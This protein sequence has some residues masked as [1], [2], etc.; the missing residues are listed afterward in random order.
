ML[1][2]WE[3]A[4]FVSG[5]KT[6]K[7]QHIT[8]SGI[9]TVLCTYNNSL[10]EDEEGFCLSYLCFVVRWFLLDQVRYLSSQFLKVFSLG[11][12]RQEENLE[13]LPT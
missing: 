8:A 9:T 5:Q 1:S 4:V 10:Q 6:N 13:S 2:S 11:Q 7:I 3:T 12:Q